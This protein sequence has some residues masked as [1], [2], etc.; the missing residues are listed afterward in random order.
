M[1][2]RLGA[3]YEDK[4]TGFTGVCTGYDVYITGCNQAQIQPKIKDN[5]KVDPMWIDEQRLIATEDAIITLDN[6]KSP[7]FCAAPPNR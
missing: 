3:T 6:S 5:T 2:V 1:E 7:G 4:I